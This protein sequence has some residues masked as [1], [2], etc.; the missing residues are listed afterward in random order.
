MILDFFDDTKPCPPEY[1]DCEK[2]R[3]DYRE[4]LSRI[5]P[6]ACK[7]CVLNSLKNKYINIIST[8]SHQ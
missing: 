3:Q 1:P 7:P 8:K 5:N 4:E 2:L 6:R